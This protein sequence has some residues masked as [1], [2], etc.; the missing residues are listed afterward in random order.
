MLDV[1]N[2]VDIARWAKEQFKQPLFLIGG[3]PDVAEIFGTT[4]AAA[5][6]SAGAL[7]GALG[8]LRLPWKKLATEAW[9]NIL[10]ERDVQ[11]KLM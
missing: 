1:Q 6:G 3:S 2:A 5:A 10:D 8:W 9:A 4:A 11:G 7:V